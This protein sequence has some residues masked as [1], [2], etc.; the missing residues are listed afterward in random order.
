MQLN[1]RLNISCSKVEEEAEN[2]NKAETIFK[3]TLL[4]NFPTQTLD[5]ESQSQAGNR[6]H[7]QTLPVTYQV[8][9]SALL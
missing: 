1:K 6:S 8:L 7:L 4:W 3:K 2:E 5:I 9:C